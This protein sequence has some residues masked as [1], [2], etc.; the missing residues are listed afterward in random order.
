VLNWA[1]DD[2]QRMIPTSSEGKNQ[3][4]L[5]LWW[6]RENDYAPQQILLIAKMA[7]G[8]WAENAFFKIHFAVGQ[9][10]LWKGERHHRDGQ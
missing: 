5:R 10:T 3:L 6:D 9:S 8:Y 4:G 2:Q 7:T 1:S